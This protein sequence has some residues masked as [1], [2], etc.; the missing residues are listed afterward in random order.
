VEAAIQK[1]LRIEAWVY[2]EIKRLAE[3]KQ[4]TFTDMVNYLL[5]EELTALGY[6]KL[7]HDAERL[8]M[9]PRGG[10]GPAEPDPGKPETPPRTR[11]GE[12]AGPRESRAG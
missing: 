9:P 4:T 5:E 8:R 6:S 2:H 10:A 1:S 7:K 11:P 12:A 3:E